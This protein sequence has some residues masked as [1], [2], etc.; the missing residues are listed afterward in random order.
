MSLANKHGAAESNVSPS[1]HKGGIGLGQQLVFACQYVGEECWRNIVCYWWFYFLRG[2]SFH[3]G[4][5][6]GCRS[7]SCGLALAAYWAHWIVLKQTLSNLWC[8]GF[9]GEFWGWFLFIETCSQFSLLQKQFAN[10]KPNL[11]MG[12]F[13]AQILENQSILEAELTIG[14]G[15]FPVVMCMLKKAEGFEQGYYTLKDIYWFC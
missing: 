13:S 4:L 15:F 10:H 5:P 6:F 11:N 2:F 9:G 3:V 7:R 14:F 1:R 8:T 12:L